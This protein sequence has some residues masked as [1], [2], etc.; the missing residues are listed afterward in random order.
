[1]PV[2]ASLPS[3]SVVYRSPKL[4]QSSKVVMLGDLLVVQSPIKKATTES[5]ITQTTTTVVH[6]INKSTIGVS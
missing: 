6:N 2:S 1:M 5:Y 4:A 3:I